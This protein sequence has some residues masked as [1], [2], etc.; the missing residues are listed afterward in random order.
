[1]AGMTITEARQKV[2]TFSDPYYDTKIV[3]YTR[4]DQKVTD[5]SEL[6]GKN[7][8]VKNGTISQTF[9]EENQEKYIG[10]SAQVKIIFFGFIS[11][12]PAS[13]RFYPPIAR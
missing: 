5:Y 12:R 13:R 4:S 6:K 9:L 10:Y 2:F 3:L 1:M 7:I 8:G 11:F